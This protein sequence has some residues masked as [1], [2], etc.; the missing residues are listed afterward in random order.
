MYQLHLS[1]A[2]LSGISYRSD[3]CCV[4]KLAFRANVK[5]RSIS[6]IFVRTL[7]TM[8]VAYTAVTV[9]GGV[10]TCFSLLATGNI[11]VNAWKMVKGIKKQASDI[12][13][14]YG[15]S[16]G[17]LGIIKSSIDSQECMSSEKDAKLDTL[18]RAMQQDVEK[19]N[20]AAKELETLILQSCKG[21]KYSKRVR[22]TKKRRNA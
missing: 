3:H 17:S 1:P 11:I 6:S 20:Y 13:E 16:A 15:K 22:N 12:L 4:T 14:L 5:L 7:N 21:K 9:S 18:V 19:A 2:E 10:K 8:A